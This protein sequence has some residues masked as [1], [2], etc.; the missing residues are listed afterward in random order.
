MADP[1]SIPEL[2]RGLYEYL[3][4]WCKTRRVQIKVARDPWHSVF[5]L[6]QA[7]QGSM[8]VLHWAGDSEFGNNLHCPVSR[9]RFEI[10]LTRPVG[11]EEEPSRRDFQGAAGGESLLG[12]LNELREKVLTYSPPAG[13]TAG[14]VRYKSADPVTTPQ[15]FPLSAYKLTVEIDAGVPPFQAR[16]T[17]P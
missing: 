16:F 5:L 2:I 7:P 13:A 6:T 8:L 12:L 14:R 4:A 3:A 1:I 17:N 10:T 9:N 15:G 11:P